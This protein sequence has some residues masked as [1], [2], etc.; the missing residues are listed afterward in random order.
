MYVVNIDLVNKILTSR[1]KYLRFFT[2]RHFASMKFSETKVELT[3][4]VNI[5]NSHHKTNQDAHKSDITYY[6]TEITKQEHPRLW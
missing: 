5:T 1:L 2:I 3:E 6:Y 4:N